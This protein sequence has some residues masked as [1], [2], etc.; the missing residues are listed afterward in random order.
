MVDLTCSEDRGAMLLAKMQAAA[1]RL[2]KWQKPLGYVFLAAL[3]VG[4]IQS[5]RYIGLG[6]SDIKIAPILILIFV[7][8]IASQTY[9]A[10]GLQLL[11]ALADKKISF[12]KAFK[13][14]GPAQLA[15]MLPI[16]GGAMVRIGLLVNAG[17]KTGHSSA[18]VIGIAVLRLALAA[19]CAGAV[20]IKIGQDI[21]W[22]FLVSGLPLAVAIF[23]WSVKLA[24]LQI[25]IFNLLHRS[26]GIVISAIRLALAFAVIGVAVSFDH[27]F[28]FTFATIAGSAASIAPSG[29][30]VSEGVAALM[31]SLVAMGAASALLA[32]AIN[33]AA[34]LAGT[35]VLVFLTY[36]PAIFGNREA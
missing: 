23:V 15:E 5:V 24:G 25:A 18:L 35:G 22:L 31:A 2:K 17:V 10:I 16:P 20:L 11:T 6:W 33:R 29:I 4:V 30:G 3:I 8:T 12:A 9:S 19:I 1:A 27:M 32:V 13:T 34:N 36:G 7:M 14:A 21:G 26:A 28:I